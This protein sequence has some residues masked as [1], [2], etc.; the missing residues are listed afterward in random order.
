MRNNDT[1]LKYLIISPLK[2]TGTRLFLYWSE[3]NSIL[4]FSV[5]FGVS[6]LLRKDDYK[7]R[8]VNNRFL[9]SRNANIHAK[10]RHSTLSSLYA[11]CSSLLL[12]DAF[13]WRLSVC[14]SVA[15]IGLNSRI[16]RPS[17]IKIGTEVTHVTRDSDITFKVKRSKVNLFANVLNSHYAGT[18]ATWRI[19]AKILS[20]CRGGGILCRHAHSLF[21]AKQD[22]LQLEYLTTHRTDLSILPRYS[23]ESRQNDN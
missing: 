20:T 4:Q 17:K 6:L 19:N 18:G 12:S 10:D 7:L 22:V 5:L 1:S 21:I 13:V 3:S 11:G 9:M 15:Y 2:R 16:E 14:L 23:D 8:I